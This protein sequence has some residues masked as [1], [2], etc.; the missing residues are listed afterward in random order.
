MTINNGNRTEWSA[1]RSVII[2]VI[3]LLAMKKKKQFK[4]MHDGVYC[5]VTQA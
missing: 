5:S 2:R 3:I 1:T 4:D